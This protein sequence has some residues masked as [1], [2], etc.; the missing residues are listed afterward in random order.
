VSTHAAPATVARIQ[1]VTAFVTGANRGIGAA[2][3][4]ALLERGAARVYAC[5]RRTASLDWLVAKYGARVVPVALDVRNDLQ[6]AAAV[7]AAPDV[8]LLIN[9]AGI[10]GHA[11]A[12]IYDNSYLGAL[13]DELGTNVVGLHS[14]TLAFTPV[15]TANA[16]TTH[17]AA[18]VN[19][20][21][22]AGLASFSAVPTYSASKAAVHSLTQAWRAALAPHHISVHGVYPG[23]IDTDMAKDIPLEKTPARDVAHA[24]L[25]GVEQQVDDIYPDPFSK[26][27]GAEYAASP[28]SLERAFAAQAAG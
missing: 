1:G 12:P 4:E 19:F 5:A 2:L 27:M 21:S 7:Q 10:V 25:D 9:N 8:Q 13:R 17:G 18:L 14:L 15:L 3:V 23:P 11:F 22:V 26:Q 6:I 24:V 28:K 20:S 16:S